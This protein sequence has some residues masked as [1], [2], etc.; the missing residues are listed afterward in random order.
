MW[1]IKILQKILKGL[2]QLTIRRYKPFIIGVTGSVGKTSTKLAVSVVLGGSTSVRAARGNLNNELGFP[3]SILGDYD[4]SKTG[5][6][7]FWIKAVLDGLWGIVFKKEYPKGWE[8]FYRNSTIFSDWV[9]HK[10]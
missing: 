10:S 9:V 4:G 1:T 5:G 6:S 8:L 3:L 2:A 7:S